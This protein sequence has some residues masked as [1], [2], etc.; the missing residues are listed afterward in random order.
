MFCFFSFKFSGDDLIIFLHI[1]KTA[2]T[3]FERFLVRKLNISFPCICEEGQRR[4]ECRV[5]DIFGKKRIWLFSRYSTG[6]VDWACGLHADFTK[7]I[8]VGCVDYYFRI[9]EGLIIFN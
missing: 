8:V 9:K 3:T 2:G 5:I 6:W 7:L 4:C 1:Q